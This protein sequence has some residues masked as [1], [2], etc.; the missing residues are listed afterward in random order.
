MLDFADVA[1][2]GKAFRRWTNTSPRDFRARART[3]E[4]P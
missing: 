4:N 2:F 1:A 3:S